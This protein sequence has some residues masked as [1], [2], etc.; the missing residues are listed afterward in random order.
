MPQQ[1]AAE[2][3]KPSCRFDKRD[4]NSTVKL[5][6]LLELLPPFSR[7]LQGNVM[8]EPVAFHHNNTQATW[9]GDRMADGCSG[10]HSCGTAWE[11]HPTS[12]RVVKTGLLNDARAHR[13]GAL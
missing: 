7:R 9:L 6:Y 2:T 13:I 8:K 3:K 12:L 4:S 5:M 1:A 11:L 10:A